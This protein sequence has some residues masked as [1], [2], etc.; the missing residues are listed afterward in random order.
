MGD[1]VRSVP[2]TGKETVMDAVGHVNGISQLS[3]TKIWIARPMPGNRD[4]STIL[5]VDWEAIS[6]R[7]INTTNYTFLPGDRLVFGEDP[8]ITRSNSIGK[9]TAPIERIDGRCF[10]DQFRAQRIER[11]ACR[12]LPGIEGIRSRRAFSPTTRNSSNSC[13]MRYA[14]REQEKKKAGPKAAE[15]KPGQEKSRARPVRKHGHVHQFRQRGANEPFSDCVQTA[16]FHADVRRV[17]DGKGVLEAARPRP[18]SSPCGLCPP[19][20]SNRRT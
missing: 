10:L 6:K 16:A 20:A 19:T 14:S 9:K 4:K 12:R 11:P 1:S 7:G 2:C 8:L 13:W 18:T 15:Q 3:S 5:T 17:S